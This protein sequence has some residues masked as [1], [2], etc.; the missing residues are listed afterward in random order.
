MTVPFTF[1]NDIGRVPAAELD[2]NFAYVSNN[3]STANTVVANAQ[4]NITSVGTLTSLSV[5]GNITGSYFFG[6]GSHLANISGINGATGATGPAGTP[7]GATGPQG[8][9]GVTGA[10]GATGATGVGATGATGPQGNTGSTGPQ[11][12]P[13]G[14][15]GPQGSTGPQ[16]A[17]GS[18]GATG[19][20]GAR[21]VA[22]I[23]GA[24]GATGTGIQGAT[25]LTGPTGAT[26]N[27]GITGATGAVGATGLTG[28]T[29][30]GATGATGPVGA[31]GP[32]NN[33]PVVIA[34]V[35]TGQS[36]STSPY[37]VST[38]GLVFDNVSTN[39]GNS[40][41]VGTSA[42][43]S[44][45]TAPVS[46]FYQLNSTISVTPAN[47][48]LVGN[49]LSAGAIVVFQNNTPVASGPFIDLRGLVFGNV[50]TGYIS[51]SS[52]S[53]LVKLTAGDTVKCV[54]E[55][56]TTAPT[57]FWNTS[58]NIIEGYFQIAYIRST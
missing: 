25:G 50:V 35:Q 39:I 44:F 27:N 47:I 11:G 7:G 20:T 6:D 58:T 12:D 29:G 36:L 42:T 53:N 18:D 22:G 2:A 21:G 31:T 54:L 33:G 10:T 52:V 15:T 24:T 28:A 13:G 26:G 34:N 1:G 32:A 37:G 57:G 8:A 45:F 23:N 38:L 41:S 40:F 3:V 5:T 49:Y 19:A 4:P 17:T 43:G 9:T 46:G 16:G 51:G 30:A 55:Y 48:A 56:Y 14:A